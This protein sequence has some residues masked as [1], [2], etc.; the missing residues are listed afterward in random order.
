V[1]ALF[2]TYLWHYLA[3]RA[4]YD[5]VVRPLARGHPASLLLLVFIATGGFLLGRRRARRRRR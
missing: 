2:I 5:E 4:I 1:S 3:A